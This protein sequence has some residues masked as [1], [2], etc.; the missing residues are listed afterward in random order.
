MK[1]N[2]WEL[3]EYLQKE[4]PEIYGKYLDGELR[5]EQIRRKLRIGFR[6]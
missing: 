3:E 2:D 4:K 5:L 6:E 1:L